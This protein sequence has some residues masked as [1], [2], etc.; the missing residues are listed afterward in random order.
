MDELEVDDVA[1]LGGEYDDEE[2]RS[3]MTSSVIMPRG[4]GGQTPGTGGAGGQAPGGSG[5]GGQTLASKRKAQPTEAKRRCR[6]CQKWQPEDNFPINSAHCR[7]CKQ[8]VDNLSK[9]AIRQGEQDWWK[10]NRNDEQELRKLVSRYMATC[11]KGVERGKRG[12]FNLVSYR[13]VYT[14]STSSAAKARGKMMWE[15]WY[16]EWAQKPKGGSYSEQDARRRWRE[17][18]ED[19]AVEKDDK[20]PPQAPVRCLVAVADEVSFGSKLSHAKTQ[21]MQSKKDQKNVAAEVAARD[22]RLLLQGH[23]RGALNKNG[24]ALDFTGAMTGMLANSSCGVSGKLGAGGSAFAGQGEFIPDIKVLKEDL[25]DE[26]AAPDAD[27]RGAG[28]E[29]PDGSAGT[30]STTA[31]SGAQKRPAET[32]LPPAK[33][34]RWFDSAAVRA[35][36]FILRHFPWAWLRKQLPGACSAFLRVCCVCKP[37]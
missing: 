5:A 1:M 17:M 11:P 14:A 13:E 18:L 7:E 24:E 25:E 22:R 27:K 16:V 37:R 34:A 28:G 8:A 9:Q 19:P 32:D 29:A 30:G 20:G 31:S 3:S 26:E 2:D 23:E 35:L 12:V 6:L 10:K 36:G 15:G 4:A 21:E 33:K